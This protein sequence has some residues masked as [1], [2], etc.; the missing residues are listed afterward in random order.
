MVTYL[1]EDKA[2]NGLSELKR[3]AQVEVLIRVYDGTAF[4]EN[5]WK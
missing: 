5:E 3:S 2:Q 1:S 4:Y